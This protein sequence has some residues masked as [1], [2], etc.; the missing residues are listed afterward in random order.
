MSHRL[1]G[2]G[3]RNYMLDGFDVYLWEV[4]NAQAPRAFAAPV[5]M[6]L[7]EEGREV[8]PA[9]TLSH[10]GA[11]KLID[12]LWNAGYRP[13]NAVNQDG[14]IAAMRDHIKSLKDM[15]DRITVNA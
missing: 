15:L 3:G 8:V 5:A 11:Q 14:T 2:G 12:D 9:A 10:Q 7:A 6:A 4:D 13:T 1:M